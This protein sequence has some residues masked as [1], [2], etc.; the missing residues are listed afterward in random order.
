MTCVFGAH[1]GLM[2]DIP[3]PP[4]LLRVR[5]RSHLVVQ[6]LESFA[7]DRLQAGFSRIDQ[8]IDRSIVDRFDRKKPQAGAAPKR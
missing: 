8:S 7:S 1:R 3:D 6:S 4:P 5:D 2:A